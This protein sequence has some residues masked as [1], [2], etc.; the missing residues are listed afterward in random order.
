[1]LTKRSIL[2]ILVAVNVALFALL[3][4]SSTHLP[5]ASAQTAAR[6]GDFVSVTA[7]PAGRTYDVVWMLDVPQQK[8]Y[9]LYPSQQSG[10]PNFVASEPRDLV[11]DFNK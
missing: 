1:M 5:A 8:L 10:P 7:T 2:S 6:R 11:R 3:L 4:M 9:A